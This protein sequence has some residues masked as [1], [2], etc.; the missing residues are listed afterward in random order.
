MKESARLFDASPSVIFQCRERGFP[1][2]NV[3]LPR[4]ECLR[5]TT[6]SA[7]NAPNT[8]S[9]KTTTT[10]AAAAAVAG[11]GA[12]ATVT[13]TATITTI[14]EESMSVLCRIIGVAI[15]TIALE[16]GRQMKYDQWQKDDICRALAAVRNGNM[17]VNEATRTY[18][19]SRKPR[20]VHAFKSKKSSGQRV[21]TTTPVCCT[22]A[23]CQ[24][25]PP[26]IIYKRSSYGEGLENI[27][28]LGTIFAYNHQS[29]YNNKD[30]FVRW[31]RHFIDTVR[32]SKEREVL[33]LD[34]HSTLTRNLDALDIALENGVIMLALPGHTAHRLQSL[35]VSCFKHLS[36]Q[37]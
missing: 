2:K 33:L 30:V 21:S 18:S 11:G 14:V 16:R 23:A 22:S 28:P 19:V 9:G 35:D 15:S 36:K 10:T 34:V 3:N 24:Y 6:F 4:E 37:T 12:T 13:A 17:G 27:A 1:V 25:V 8:D 32:P 20:K 31:L 29:G 5:R 7:T 26:L